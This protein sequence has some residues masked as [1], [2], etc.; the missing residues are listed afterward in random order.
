MGAVAI[1]KRVDGYWGGN[2]KTPTY[3]ECYFVTFL[4][5]LGEEK[6]YRVGKENFDAIYEGQASMLV[7]VEGKFFAFDDGEEIAECEE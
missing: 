6:E 4:T 3:N 1:S 2:M 7:T 5:D